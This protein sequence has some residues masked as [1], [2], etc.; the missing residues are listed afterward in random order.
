MQEKWLGI[1]IMVL[2]V[3]VSGCFGKGV[4]ITR[5]DY[6]IDEIY[7]MLKKPLSD[8]SEIIRPSGVVS[9]SELQIW[10][11][12]NQEKSEEIWEQL[13]RKGVLDSNGKIRDQINLNDWKIDLGLSSENDKL[14]A[15]ILRFLS[16]NHPKYASDGGY[17]YFVGK[18]GNG[19]EDGFAPGEKFKGDPEYRFVRNAGFTEGIRFYRDKSQTLKMD[20]RYI[21]S[22]EPIFILSGSLS[23]IISEKGGEVVTDNLTEKGGY[24]LLSFEPKNPEYPADRHQYI[25][26]SRKGNNLFFADI[27]KSI[28]KE[29]LRKELDLSIKS[30]PEVWNKYFYAEPAGK[31]LP[32]SGPGQGN[33]PGTGEVIS[34]YGPQKS[35]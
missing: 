19:R 30:G 32:G 9:K 22:T 27:S 29:S 34:P 31:Y 4:E 13:R 3:L 23:G 17:S 12:T 18:Y 14:K 24:I 20:C 33:R 8:S 25:M 7:E 1:P 35:E 2:L 28:I 10:L 26:V 6:T 21:Y 5:N 16:E 11:A 15:L